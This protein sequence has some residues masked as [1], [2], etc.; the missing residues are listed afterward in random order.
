VRSFRFQLFAGTEATAP[1]IDQPGLTEPQLTLTDLPPGLYSWRISATRVKNGDRLRE[2]RAA[3]VVAD[4]KLG[5]G[6]VFEPGPPRLA[7]STAEARPPAI[8]ASAAAALAGRR[9]PDRPGL[10]GLTASSLT[11]RLDNILYDRLVRA[12]SA[13]SILRS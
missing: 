4:R 13:R 1:I 6:R 5:L 7:L 11:T 12:S 2:G 9:R 8:P 10:A 3:A